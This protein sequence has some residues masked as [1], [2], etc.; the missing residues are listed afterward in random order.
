MN[1]LTSLHVERNQ[2]HSGE[3]D[4]LLLKQ[5]VGDLFRD[6]VVQSLHGRVDET[7]QNFFDH[8]GTVED[9]RLEEVISQPNRRLKLSVVRVHSSEHRLQQ[10]VAKAER[11]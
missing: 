1:A 3:E 6:E 11:G 10:A 7:E 5:V 2:I 9:G 8:V 4:F